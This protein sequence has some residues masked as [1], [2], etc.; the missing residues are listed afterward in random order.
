MSTGRKAFVILTILTVFLTSLTGLI[1]ILLS[2]RTLRVYGHSMEPTL[3]YGQIV[4]VDKSFIFRRGV[5]RGDIV[6]YERSAKDGTLIIGR[7]VALPDEKVSLLNGSVYINGKM[8]EEPYAKGATLGG[9][10]IVENKEYIV[11]KDEYLILGDN[12]QKSWDSRSFGF[13][14]KQELRGIALFI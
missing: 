14:Q 5:S 10:A 9:T 2:I 12:R 13:V 11:P 4:V 6:S 3:K 8:L 1:L 7:I